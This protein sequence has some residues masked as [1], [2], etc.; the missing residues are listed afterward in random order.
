[1]PNWGLGPG[2]LCLASS[3]KRSLQSYSWPQKLITDAPASAPVPVDRA[4]AG[5]SNGSERLLVE[6]AMEAGAGG[7]VVSASTGARTAS[8]Q[9]WPGRCWMGS[10]SS[11]S[12]PRLCSPAPLGQVQPHSCPPCSLNPSLMGPCPLRVAPRQPRTEVGGVCAGRQ[13]SA[14]RGDGPYWGWWPRCGGAG[15]TPTAAHLWGV[16]AVPVG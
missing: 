15:V 1:M 11:C 4:S 12:L 7:A 16:S 14:V 5:G 8:T 6:V 3:W 2:S 9:G 13:W 10:C